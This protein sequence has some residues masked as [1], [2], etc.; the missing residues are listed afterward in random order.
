MDRRSKDFEGFPPTLAGLPEWVAGRHPKPLTVGR[1]TGGGVTGLGARE[2]R[3]RVRDIALGLTALGLKRG[4]R[5]AIISESRPEWLHVDLAAQTL[6]VVD[7]PVYPTLSTGQTE[8][9]LRDCSARFAV[10]SS[11]EQ[12]AKVREAAPRLPVLQ[13][14]IM[15]DAGWVREPSDR[16]TILS[17]TEVAEQGSARIREGWGIVKEY[18]DATKLVQPGDLATII[19]T[20][21]TT[22]EPKGVMLTHNNLVTN[23]MAAAALLQVG[24]EDTALSFLPLSH[25]FERLASYL[26]LAVGV[27]I[28]FAESMETIARDLQIVKP[29]VITG[30][31][32]VYEKLYT[33]IT[34]K[35]LAET[36]LKKKIFQWAV[37]IA[38]ERGRSLP[39]AGKPA[40]V[41]EGVRAKLADRL[42]LHKVR[43]AVGGRVR[44]MVSGSAALP[45]HLGQFFY[46]CGLTV[47]EGYGL[48]E[49]AP[50]LTVTPHTAVRFGA[51]GK[52]VPGVELRIAE[53]GEILARGPNIMQGY[54]NKPTET[55]E[56]L[57][58]GW[59]HTGDVGS[60]DSDGYLHIT[61]RKKDLI[62][63]AGGKK[64]APQPLEAKLKAHPVVAE[65][66]VIGEGR[67]FVAALFVPNGPA[68]AAALGQPSHT[69]PST[70]VERPE[71][72]ALFQAALDD[73]NR[74]LGQFE[75]LKKFSFLPKPLT[76]AD[77]ELTPS[78]KVRRPVIEKKYKDII[79]KMYGGTPPV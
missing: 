19:Y 22:G 14:V 3:D 60:I 71:A 78:L 10:V 49:T 41:F 53:D 73:V 9:I 66:I 54:Y 13:T 21:G 28:I 61:D 1:V 24:H 12:L 43:D 16:F 58:D 7:V 31:P 18:N 70:L 68:L 72:R 62:V 48:T 38:N 11:P 64:I 35:G 59:F 44:F 8:Y 55:A 23:L 25:S 32:R 20:S 26:Y 57:K 36:G 29:T 5:C 65:A 4:D 37:K 33:R 77:N 52:A 39:L 30:V 74:G 67:K 56:V 45:T 34:E 6:G 75:K 15:L 79:E 42:V 47:M 2:L 17:L 51:V 69:D 27:T 76:Q 46:G 63:T 50:V 40:H